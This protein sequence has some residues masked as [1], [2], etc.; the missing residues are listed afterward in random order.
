[1]SDEVELNGKRYISSKRASEV[2][3][4]ARDY[5]GQL[6]RSGSIDAQRVGGLWYV[7]MDSLDAYKKNADSYIPTPPTVQS[8]SDSSDTIVTFDGKEYISAARAAKLTAYNQDYIGQLARS[9]KILSRQVGNRWYIERKGL[10]E[11]KSQ[12]DGLLAA[13]RSEAVGLHIPSKGTALHDR[14]AS[15]TNYGPVMTYTVETNDLLPS[16]QKRAMETREDTFVRPVTAKQIPIR[17]M[18]PMHTPM[19]NGRG[20]Q[21]IRPTS[22]VRTPRITMNRAINAGVVMTFV[23]VLSYGY[24]SLKQGSLYTFKNGNSSAIISQQV[25]TANAYSALDSLAELVESWIAPT[26]SYKRR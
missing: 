8:A 2:G 15:E 20:I 22:P 12:K 25:L 13:V 23:V 14:E 19:I 11:H 6:A 4:Y 9:G 24:V 18:R 17:I 7:N 5:I 26:A 21:K 10:L 1:M 3:G 16:L